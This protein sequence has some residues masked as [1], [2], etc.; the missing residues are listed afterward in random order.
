MRYQYGLGTTELN[1]QY[2]FNLGIPS[3]R[4][5]FKPYSRAIVTGN[6]GMLGQGYA[7]DTW[8]WSVIYDTSRNILRGYCPNL[9]APVYVR[10]YNDSLATPAWE[11][12][13]SIMVWM[14]EAEDRQN[15]SRLKLSVTF[16]LL[17]KIS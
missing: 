16:R 1:V 17:E 5:G 3:P 6:L 11:L 9:S 14:L 15:A 13:R 2:L 8:D 12:Y 4:N 10:T 7:T